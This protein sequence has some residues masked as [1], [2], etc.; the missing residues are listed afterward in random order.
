MG[1]VAVLWYLSLTAPRAPLWSQ[2]WC[3]PGARRTHEDKQLGNEVADSLPWASASVH[4]PCR[5]PQPVALAPPR[6]DPPV[7]LLSLADGRA[8]GM[9]PT[10]HAPGARPAQRAGRP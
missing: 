5:E 2:A 9:A 4:R 8:G 6:R 1:D 7:R 10:P 3:T